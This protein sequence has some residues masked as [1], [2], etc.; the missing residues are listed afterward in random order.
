[1]PVLSFSDYQTSFQDFD[2]IIV[3]SGP[4]GLT[5]AHSLRASPFRIAILE[6][7]G[8]EPTKDI[9]ALNEIVSV[10]HRRANPESVR[11]RCVGGTSTIWTGRCGMFDAIDYVRRDWLTT[12]GWPIDIDDMAGQ[13]RRAGDL[14][15]LTPNLSVT[16]ALRDLRQPVDSRA[17]N[18]DLLS[19]VVWQFS[20]RDGQASTEHFANSM[21]SPADE[22]A[23]LRHSG[24][25]TPVDFGRAHVGWI[26]Q[27]ETV[28]LFTHATVHEVL[29]EDTGKMVSGLLVRGPDGRIRKLTA[30]RVVLACGGIDNTRLLLASRSSKPAGL[31]N[32]HDQVGRYLTDHTFTEFR[33]FGPGAARLLRRRFATR[34]YRQSGAVQSYSFGLR[35]SPALQRREGLLNASVHLV[36]FGSRTNPLASIASGVR[37]LRGD[38]NLV[39]A[40]N[41]I[42]QGLAHPVALCENV[43]DR[44][45]LGRTALNHPDR[46]VM[47]GSVE[48][49][50]NPDSRIRLSDRTDRFGMPLPE[51]DWRLSELEYRTAARFREILANE[52]SRLGM[53]AGNGASWNDFE[54]WRE[55]L[56]DLAHPMCTTRMSD[57]P[58]TGVV[59]ANCQVHG[60]EGLFVAGGSVFSTPGHMNPTQM[61]VALALRLAEHLNTSMSARRTESVPLRPKIRIGLVGAGDRIQRVY[62]PALAAVSDRIEVVGVAARRQLSAEQVA[63]KMGCAVF[64]DAETLVK[65]G[66]I[67]F[68]VVSVSD[69]DATYARLAHLGCPLFLETP[70]CWSLFKGRKLVKQMKKAQ[71]TVG[72]AE[73]FPF[74]PQA[75]LQRKVVE[76][77]GIGIVKSATN[78][79]ANYDYHGVARLRRALDIWD[80]IVSV[81]ARRYHVTGVQAPIDEA[82]F[83]YRSGAGLVHRFTTDDNAG[84]VLEPASFIVDGDE[85]QLTD[86]SGV[87]S[88]QASIFRPQRIEDASGDLIELSVETP[89]GKVRWRNPFVSYGLTD[90]QIAVATLLNEMAEAV[91]HAGSPAYDAV[92]GL[93]DVELLAAMRASQIRGGRRMGIGVS[94]VRE[95]LRKLYGK[96][97]AT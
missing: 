79:L 6:S 92:D 47:G 91:S 65:E 82:L 78:N 60:V 48:Q 13:V 4:A 52:I 41:S 8:I 23:I 35:L 69:N 61:I 89:V 97:N 9:E 11:R 28:F 90:E 44:F 80:E 26:R 87:T 16:H 57:D 46:T 77:G 37:S 62:A 15:G 75:R 30:S 53:E 20:V 21:D 36:E 43:A 17:W 85:G 63:S 40:A 74:L 59:D 7:G 64:P 38:R 51:I 58:A 5:I 24:R 45:V 84:N 94:V 27:S 49:L 54:S 32:D 96:R 42:V 67:D 33:S 29:A 12:S 95:K 19:P 68:L 25:K 1:M 14:L 18:A 39:E 73:Q 34:L 88:G 3:G 76:L 50:L 71:L 72:L 93:N 70:I 83:H 81:S 55:D 86:A 10:G 31:G 2:L 56:I 66:R 22:L